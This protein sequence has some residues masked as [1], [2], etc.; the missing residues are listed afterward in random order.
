[1]S[2]RRSSRWVAAARTTRRKRSMEGSAMKAGRV[3]RTD[4]ALRPDY[5]VLASSLL[6]RPTVGDHELAPGKAEDVP[7]RLIGEVV[8]AAGL[9]RM[10]LPALDQRGRHGDPPVELGLGDAEGRAMALG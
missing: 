5:A 1:T 9:G 7:A 8:I 3:D 4:S 2:W 10:R 6:V